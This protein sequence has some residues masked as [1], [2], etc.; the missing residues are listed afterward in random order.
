MTR[1]TALLTLALLG[2]AGPALAADIDDIV[3]TNLSAQAADND[4]GPEAKERERGGRSGTRTTRTQTRSSAAK[5]G[6]QGVKVTQSRSQTTTSRGPARTPPRAAPAPARPGPPARPGAV[7]T[8]ARPGALVTRPGAVVHTRPGAARPTVVR[9]PVVAH[10]RP[11]VVHARPGVVSRRPAVVHQRTVVYRRVHP[12]HGVFV[13]GPRP[14]THVHYHDTGNQNVRRVDLP[15][16][17]VDRNDSLAIGFK[18][19]S[20]ISST[21]DQRVYGDPGLGLVGRYRPAETVGLELGVQRHAGSLSSDLARSN[22]QATGSVALF[23]F[24]WTRVSPYAIG[25]VT[26]NAANLG[27]EVI[28]GD[29]VSVARTMDAQWGLHGGLGVEFALGDNF[30][31]DLEGRYIGWIDERTPGEA[32]G[33]VQATA[34]VLLHFK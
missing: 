30:A 20:M 21:A 5:K 4:R 23:A 10:A 29:T 24:P 1:T 6:G 28:T 11:G 14:A 16:R 31:L 12:Y 2:L 27:S 22:T 34:G 25:G 7:V 9:P 19:G 15:E 32:P 3:P 17:A 18:G 26:Y 13:Y 8:H 33:A